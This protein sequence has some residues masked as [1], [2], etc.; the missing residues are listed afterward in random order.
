MRQIVLDQF[1]YDTRWQQ[2]L[3]GIAS[4]LRQ[5]AA[6]RSENTALSSAA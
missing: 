1:S 3:D 5:A 6:S 2:F 4:G